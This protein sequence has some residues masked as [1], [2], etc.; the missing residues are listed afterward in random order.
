MCHWLSHKSVTFNFS[1]SFL[2][3]KKDL[4]FNKDLEM[5]D[6]LWDYAVTGSIDEESA[7]INL[8]V[9][10]VDGWNFRWNNK[11]RL[12]NTFLDVEEESN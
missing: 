10:A 2:R 3:E 9:H 6:W 5:N 1:G 8:D 4:L 7:S 11:L 12:L